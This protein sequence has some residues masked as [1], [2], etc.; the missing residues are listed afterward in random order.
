MTMLHLR[1]PYAPP[2]VSTSVSALVWVGVGAVPAITREVEPLRVEPT[3]VTRDDVMRYL[4]DLLFPLIGSLRKDD[5]WKNLVWGNPLELELSAAEG[6]LEAESID[7]CVATDTPSAWDGEGD[8]PILS[9]EEEKEAG[10]GDTVYRISH[11]ADPLWR[12]KEARRVALTLIRFARQLRSAAKARKAKSAPIE[13]DRVLWA[14]INALWKRAGLI[15]D[16][17]NSSLTTSGDDFREIQ[18]LDVDMQKMRLD[19]TDLTG[20]KPTMRLPSR[21]ESPG[22]GV[23]WG[24]IVFAAVLAAG[25]LLLGQVRGFI[26]LKVAA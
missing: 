18:G 24:W 12:A 26:P 7:G 1:E 22:S 10:E 23:P 13:E 25:A 3:V 21:V 5:A 15:F 17:I 2:I 9:E 19:Y 11:R 14:N 4:L 6:L 20:L 16:R 8:C